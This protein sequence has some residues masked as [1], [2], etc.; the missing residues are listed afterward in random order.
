[1]WS[2]RALW[3]KN[4]GSQPHASA[5][6]RKFPKIQIPAPS[7]PTQILTY[8]V[9]GGTSAS[10]FLK[11]SQ[12][13]LAADKFEFRSLSHFHWCCPG[14]HIPLPSLLLLYKHS[15]ELCFCSSLTIQLNRLS[16][17]PW[18]FPPRIILAYFSDMKMVIWNSKDILWKSHS[19][20][21]F[22][23]YS[24]KMGRGTFQSIILPVSDQA[25]GVVQWLST[26]G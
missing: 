4:S 3:P 7:L 20:G 1:M 5:S 2:F 15:M 13:M 14:R 26:L 16:G 11:A 21:Y 18:K 19:K 9:C 8:K 17:I 12:R 23:I 10:M 6:Y 22:L 25:G 24:E